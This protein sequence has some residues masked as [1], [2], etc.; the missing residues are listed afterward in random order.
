MSAYPLPHLKTSYGKIHNMLL[1]SY[2]PKIL[3]SAMDIGLFEALADTTLTS[4][5]LAHNLDTDHE[6]TQAMCNVLVNH[7]FLDTQENQYMLSPMS[8]EFLLSGSPVNQLHDIRS[9][10]GSQ[11]PFDSL[12][13]LLTKKRTPQFDQKMWASQESMLSMAQGARAGGAQAVVEFTT[14][15]PEFEH[16][17]KMCDLAGGSG[18]YTKAI[19]A[20]NAALEG[21]VYDLPEVVEIAGDLV[22][23]TAPIPHFHAFDMQV[24]QG[25]GNDYDLFFVSHFLYKNGSDGSLPQFLRNVNRALLPGG[26]FVSN[27][28]PD[29]LP[30]EFQPIMSMVELMTRCVGYPAHNLPREVLQQALLEAGFD[31]ITMQEPRHDQP[32]PTLLL[33]AR[34][35]REL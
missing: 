26:V 16:C 19:M 30:K 6:I 31:T 23:E 3:N 28:I 13:E 12:T 14:S 1:A 35:C 8:I 27:H 24:D 20:C 9:Y 22:K 2:L 17:R 10:S 21:H 7:S 32:Y 5:D 25:F 34:K 4:E 29:N 18:H 33:A 15:L 11:G